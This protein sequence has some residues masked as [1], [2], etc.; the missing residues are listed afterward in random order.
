MASQPADH[1]FSWP[2]AHNQVSIRSGQVQV[3][4]A[5]GR[6]GVGLGAHLDS[7]S[8]R[9]AAGRPTA[10]VGAFRTRDLQRDSRWPARLLATGRPTRPA[11]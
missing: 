6:K 9:K 2:A 8:R 5:A 3:R 11:R 7:H 1:P 10:R 4:A